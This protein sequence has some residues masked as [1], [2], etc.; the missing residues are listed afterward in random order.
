M[1]GYFGW[2]IVL[3]S[4][5]AIAGGFLIVKRATSGAPANFSLVATTTLM[6]DAKPMP[7]LSDS[8]KLYKNEQMG[9]ALYYPGDLPFREYTDHPPELTVAFQKE[10]GTAAFQIYAAPIDGNEITRARF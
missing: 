8:A 1:K 6:E 4:V 7:A 9:F 10:E 3:C 5:M 2:I